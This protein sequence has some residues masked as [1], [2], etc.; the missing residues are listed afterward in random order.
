MKPKIFVDGRVFDTEYQGT[1]TYIHNLYKIIDDIGDFEIFLASSNPENAAGFFPGCRNIRFIQYHTT[2]KLRRALYELPEMMT[3]YHIDAAHYQYVAPPR[4]NCLQ[5]VTIHDLLFKDFP[6]EFSLAYKMTK[7]AAFYFSAKRADLVT[8]VSDYS[9]K[10]IVRHFSI[11]EGNIH[12]VPNGVSNFYFEPFD[13]EKAALE[14]WEKFG[15]R[16]Y[17]LYVSRI[18]PRKNQ[19][20]LLRAYLDLKLY[21]Q[22]KS[23]VFVGKAS[24]PVPQ[25]KEILQPLRD[26]IKQKIF[27][28]ENI[29]NADLRLLYQATALFVYPSKGEGFGIPPL[30]AAALGIPTI[31][32]NTTAM[33]EFSFFGDRH[34]HP[35]ITQLKASITRALAEQPSNLREISNTIRRRYGWEKAAFTMNE[36]IW[37][38][39]RKPHSIFNTSG[40]PSRS[41]PVLD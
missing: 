35:D 6:G 14:V 32:S 29:S 26:E 24:I 41:A 11:P 23:L 7:S 39:V 12:V 31:C 30:E 5:I 28:L 40:A 22:D 15:L 13:Q 19:V 38:K 3:R 36:L 9:K 1:R 4:K 33:E 27:F 2:S 37:K 10:A 17:I 25:L 34:I 20:D 21:E 16:D 18:E 8:T